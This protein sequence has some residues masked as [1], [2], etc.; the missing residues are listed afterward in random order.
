ME[1]IVKYLESFGVKETAI[2]IPIIQRQ[3]F[4]N[5]YKPKEVVLGTAG[6]KGYLAY[7]F[8]TIVILESVRYG[9]AIYVFE[10]TGRSFQN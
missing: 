5:S 2:G 7:V 1:R 8:N 4:L 9:N 6:F 3:E 10:K